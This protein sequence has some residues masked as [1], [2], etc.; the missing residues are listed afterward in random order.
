V[1]RM[2]EHMNPYQA[3]KEFPLMVSHRSNI[4]AVNLNRSSIMYYRT[5]ISRPASQSPG[6][7]KA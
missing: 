5:S 6:R 2:H 4:P 7:P 1:G 3:E